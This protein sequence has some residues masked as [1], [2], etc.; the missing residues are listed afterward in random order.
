MII[1]LFIAT[2][3]LSFNFVLALIPII[4]ILIL[5]FA[6]GGS[7]SG[8]SILGL[9]GF[10]AI[11]GAVSGGNPTK[12]VKRAGKNLKKTYEGIYKNPALMES[13]NQLGYSLAEGVENARLY[14]K[15]RSY[16]LDSKVSNDVANS[17]KAGFESINNAIENDLKPAYRSGQALN[18]SQQANLNQDIDYINDAYDLYA[19]S[20]ADEEVFYNK[21]FELLRKNPELAKSLNNHLMKVIENDKLLPKAF[22]KAPSNATDAEKLRAILESGT[23]EAAVLRNIIKNSVAKGL[24]SAF[25][26]RY[27]IKRVTNNLAW[28]ATQVSSNTPK[29][30]LKSANEAN[31]AY[32]NLARAKMLFNIDP[33]A[34]ITAEAYRRVIDQAA[35]RHLAG[36]WKALDKMY[37]GNA[38]LPSYMS[39]GFYSEEEFL[40]KYV[41]VTSRTGL[42]ETL[43]GLYGRK[44]NAMRAHIKVLKRLASIEAERNYYYRTLGMHIKPTNPLVFNIKE[45]YYGGLRRLEKATPHRVSP[46][47]RKLLE[48][49][50]GKVHS[51]KIELKSWFILP[52]TF[53]A[54][55]LARHPK[56]IKEAVRKAL[57]RQNLR[58][59]LGIA[60]R[61]RR[62]RNDL[63]EEYLKELKEKRRFEKEKF[64]N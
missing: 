39:L 20:N 31:I 43:S 3:I 55:R 33:D 52:T 49:E 40:N 29:F 12:A 61:S 24:E 25:A 63:I 18:Q 47:F 5:L 42:K 10:S 38:E 54:M 45:A 34:N 30:R 13:F 53:E 22:N 62:E 1:Y 46:V 59:T 8:I 35:D 50:K 27:N 36:Y 57:T 58:K 44:E 9:I 6:A 28:Y 17:I 15:A 51:G 14:A 56:D 60:K 2:Y 48:D 32:E 7:R 19:A 23:P 16:G 21:F 64:I 41:N 26:D 4:I 37:K 11:V